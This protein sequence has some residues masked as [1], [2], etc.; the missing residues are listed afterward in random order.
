MR[1]GVSKW[2]FDI[3]FGVMVLGALFLMLAKPFGFSVDPTALTGYGAI[4]TYVLTQR[5]SWTKK[6]K[7]PPKEPPDDVT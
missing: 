1:S 2:Q 5:G 6:T 3:L 7:G 4:T